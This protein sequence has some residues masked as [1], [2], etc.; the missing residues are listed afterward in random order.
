MC[1]LYY[2]RITNSFG[3]GEVAAEEGSRESDRLIFPY[4]TTAHTKTHVTLSSQ[5]HRLFQWTT[6]SR[7]LLMKTP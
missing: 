2:S 6:T 3:G 7:V 5:K 4:N 1:F